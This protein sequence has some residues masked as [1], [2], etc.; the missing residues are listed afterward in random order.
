[1]L[2]QFNS[3][4]VLWTQ[5]SP[6]RLPRGISSI[7]IGTVYHPPSSMDFL[8]LDY[9]YNSL[10]SIEASFPGCG[11]I[12][13]GDFNQLN[14]SRLCNFY[15]LKQIVNFPTRGSNT[16][17][18]IYTNL[19][20]FYSPPIKMSPFG[21]SDH[22]S[23]EVK[24]L[25]RTNLPKPKITV[26]SRDIR[27]SKRLAMRLY[28]KEVDISTLINSQRSCEDKVKLL[29]LIINT[30]MDRLLPLKSK[31][32]VTS[33]PPWINQSLKCLIRKRQKALDQGDEVLFRTLR[34]RVNLSNILN[35][36]F[37]EA[38][39]P[40]SWKLANI[41]PIPKQKQILDVNSHLRPISLTSILSKVAEDFVVEEFVKPAVLKKVDPNQLTICTCLVQNL[42]Y[43]ANGQFGTIPGSNTTQALISMLHSWNKATDGSGATVRTVLVDFKKAFDLIDHHIL[44]DKL[45]SYDIPESIVLWVIDFL[46]C[47]KQRVKLGNDCYS[48]WGTI[49]SGVP[50]GTKLGPWLFVIMIN[51]LKI[52]D[53]ELWK[54]VDDTTMSEIVERNN[55]SNIQEKVDELTRHISIDKLTLNES[56]CK[57][58]RI[59]F[60]KSPPDFDPITINNKQLEV[61][62]SVKLLG[63]QIS[64]DLKWNSHISVIMKK[65]NKRLYFLSQ[66]KRSNSM[67]A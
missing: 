54:Y 23:I 39:L 49:P 1:S 41:S 42:V 52:Q 63:M 29:E 26:K 56:K 5:I 24:P 44:V 48:E 61:V 36:S 19:K 35:R 22:A 31:T 66:L 11:I 20:R 6:Q 16:L 25:E 67:A 65:A 43:Y 17:D 2:N 8:M 7:V 45:K 55:E 64:N 57:E 18:K 12:L 27:P 3:I 10:S 13:L 32:I 30:G 46:T 58:L 38:R 59:S 9:L 28:L 15:K 53:S 60:S 37:L 62:E 51:D 33:E 50:Q 34:N 40:S 21:L 47:R 14:G 4:Q